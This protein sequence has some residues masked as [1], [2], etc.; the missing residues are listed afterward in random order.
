MPTPGK[1]VIDP[2]NP[3]GPDG[4][5]G[6]K[7]TLPDGVSS[8]SVIAGMLPA[9]THF[10]KA[11]GT[12]SAEHL[13]NASNRSPERAVLFYA[14]DDDA[15]GV[16]AER[17]I[18]LAGFAAVKVGGLD[19]AIRI[20]AFGDLHDLGGLGGRLLTTKEANALLADTRG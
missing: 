2:S 7:R 18:S 17:L 8:G 6:F 14:T 15:A 13:A 12:V 16:R 4:K 20:E 3:I 11:F 19:Q 10:V 9:R 5:G 1:V